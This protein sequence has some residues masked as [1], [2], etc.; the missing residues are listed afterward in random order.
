MFPRVTSDSF[1]VMFYAVRGMMYYRKALMLQ[2]HLE[3]RSL[4]G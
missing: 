4:E 3:R 1:L 2:S